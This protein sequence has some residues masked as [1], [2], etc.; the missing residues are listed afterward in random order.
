MVAGGG[1][2]VKTG[3]ANKLEIF[4]VNRSSCQAER[5]ASIDT[6]STALMNGTVF[7][8]DDEQYIAA[9]GIGGH[10]QVFKARLTMDC[11]IRMNG[12]QKN[13]SPAFPESNHQNEN[14]TY[15]RRRNSSSSSRESLSNG[16]IVKSP[17]V[18]RADGDDERRLTFDVQPFRDFR[19]DFNQNPNSKSDDSFLKT[20]KFC[21]KSNTLITGGSDGHVRLWNFPSLMTDDVRDIPAHTGEIVDLDLDATSESIVTIASDG[22]CRRWRMRDGDKISDLEY[23]IPVAKDATKSVKYKFKNCRFY[24]LPDAPFVLFTTLVPAKWSKIPDPCYL[25]RWDVRTCL[26]DRRII[27]GTDSPSHMSMR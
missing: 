13:G 24:P 3:V 10:C 16:H 25:C 18:A 15:L 14:N 23:V 22:S 21:N 8:F 4:D 11:D 26:N 2:A 17:A 6:A 27:I 5:V 9:G 19:C 12:M 1:G 7:E 20:V